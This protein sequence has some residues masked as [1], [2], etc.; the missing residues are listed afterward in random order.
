LHPQIQKELEWMGPLQK[1]S[2]TMG[3]L[4]LGDETYPG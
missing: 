1:G 4:L 2:P 3:S